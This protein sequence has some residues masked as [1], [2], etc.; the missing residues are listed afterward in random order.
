MKEM[1]S[2]LLIIY[3]HTFTPFITVRSNF[4]STARMYR[5][6][7]SVLSLAIA[8]KGLVTASH[9]NTDCIELM[10]VIIQVNHRQNNCVHVDQ[11]DLLAEVQ[12]F[13]PSSCSS[14]FSKFPLQSQFGC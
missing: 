14:L 3:S 10:R 5:N 13:L 8:D 2:C 7:L 4:D 9:K 12:S 6:E 11:E 1:D